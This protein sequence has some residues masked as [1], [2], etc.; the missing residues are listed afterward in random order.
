MTSTDSQLIWLG[1]SVPQAL[2]TF[3]VVET[4]VSILGLGLVL[5]ADFLF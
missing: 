2:R 3:T 4:I 1:V 5:L